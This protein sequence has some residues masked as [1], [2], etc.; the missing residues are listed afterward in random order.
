[1]QRNSNSSPGSSLVGNDMFKI[2][3]VIVEMNQI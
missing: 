1:M 2:E 3:K